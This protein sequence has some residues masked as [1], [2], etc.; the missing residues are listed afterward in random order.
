MWESK[1]CTHP[2][3]D[4]VCLIDIYDLCAGD[5]NGDG[6]DY[7]AINACLDAIRDM[8]VY[9]FSPFDELNNPLGTLFGSLLEGSVGRKMIIDL[10]IFGVCAGT[11]WSKTWFD[12]WYANLKIMG[13]SESRFQTSMIRVFL[14]E[15]TGEQRPDLMARCTCRDHPSV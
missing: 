2:N 6:R 14:G 3:G 4:L 10:L 7:Q 11:N 9:D 5:L 15:R 8:L 13:Q 1:D 12:N